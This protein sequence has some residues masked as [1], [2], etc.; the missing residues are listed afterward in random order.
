MRFGLITSRSTNHCEA[1]STL[2]LTRLSPR[3]ELLHQ[4]L[5]STSCTAGWSISLLYKRDLYEKKILI[6]HSYKV[7]PLK[8]SE[9]HGLS[10]EVASRDEEREEVVPVTLVRQ[11]EERDGDVLTPILGKEVS[12]IFETRMLFT[13]I[14]DKMRPQ[15]P[16]KSIS[17]KC[18]HDPK[19]MA[20]ATRVVSSSIPP[21]H[22]YFCRHPTSTPWALV[23]EHGVHFSRRQRTR[24]TRLSCANA[25]IR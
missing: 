21:T 12:A 1:C 5:D 3:R 18:C 22:A 20:E 8:L 4:L 6:S 9:V 10:L 25:A 14:A 24:A 7:H 19:L 2:H 23:M 13:F 15:R 16:D 17:H 11:S